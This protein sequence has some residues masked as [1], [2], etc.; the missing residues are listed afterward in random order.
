MRERMN[1]R[2]R[3]LRLALSVSVLG[4]TVAGCELAVDFDRSKIDGGGVDAAADGTP[5]DGASADGQPD[6]NA[7]DTNTEDTNAGDTSQPET[8][9][10]ETSTPDADAG[11]ADTS[12]PDSADVNQPDTADV[13]APD[14]TDANQADTADGSA[15]DA[16]DAADAADASA[17]DAGDASDADASDGATACNALT[18]AGLT[19][20]PIAASGNA[21]PALTGGALQDGTYVLTSAIAYANGVDGGGFTATSRWVVTNAATG[22][23]TIQEAYEDTLGHAFRTRSLTLDTLADAG[24]GAAIETDTC[25]VAAPAS[26]SYEVDLVDGGGVNIDYTTGGSAPIVL[27]YTKQ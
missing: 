4:V 7:G 9:E 12:V 21:A 8:G 11:E 3:A 10:P 16:A 15:V 13:N 27:T 26:V 5:P 24:I 25:P 23:A 17:A 18:N 2:R 19:P 14:V 6:T 22:I 20:A 1:A